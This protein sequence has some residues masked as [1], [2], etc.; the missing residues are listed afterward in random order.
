MAVI[1][2]LKCQQTTKYD[3]PPDLCLFLCIG[4]GVPKAV[5]SLRHHNEE[6]EG[7][8]TLELLNGETSSDVEP[9]PSDPSPLLRGQFQDPEPPNL[10]IG[11]QTQRELSRPV[12]ATSAAHSSSPN[13]ATFSTPTPSPLN[14]RLLNQIRRD[15]T[16]RSNNRIT[17]PKT[18]ALLAQPNPGDENVVDE[19]NGK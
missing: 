13:N 8:D 16:S 3:L 10:L 14:Q 7:V 15:L 1:P 11:P 12:W 4:H 19:L 18:S 9:S 2:V 17:I 6:E 5:P